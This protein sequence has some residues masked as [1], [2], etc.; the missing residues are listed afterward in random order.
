MA[1]K[2]ASLY[3]LAPTPAVLSSP[4]GEPLFAL[5]TF[6]GYHLA[7]KRS[8]VPSACVL[9]IATSIRATGVLAS[10]ILG[11]LPLFPDD[12]LRPHLAR[13]PLAAL[14]TAIITSP[15]LAGQWYWYT[16]LCPAAEWCSNSIPLVYSHVQAK[17][18]CVPNSTPLTQARRSAQLLDPRTASESGPR[19]ARPRHVILRH[20][21]RPPPHPLLH[22]APRPHAPPRVLCALADRTASVRDRPGSVVDRGAAGIRRAAPHAFW[23]RLGC[24]GRDLWRN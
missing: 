22:P 11:W 12:S 10:G 20:L 14:T 7:V 9:A 18:W 3:L 15:F 2:T 23:T 13:L 8:W 6:T 1:W 24:L 19:R 16:Q 4:Y 5:L 17:Y 21:A